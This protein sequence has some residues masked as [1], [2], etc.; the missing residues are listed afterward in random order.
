[1]NSSNTLGYIVTLLILLCCSAIASG[2]I[3]YISLVKKLNRK[4]NF[5]SVDTHLS[6]QN[7]SFPISIYH[8]VMR[9]EKL[10][11]ILFE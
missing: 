7:V 8:E 3:E 6:T 1:M 11:T 9:K 10:M 4:K 2:M 5:F